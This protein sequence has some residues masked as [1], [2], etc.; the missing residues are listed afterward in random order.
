MLYIHPPTPLPVLSTIP[1]PR[2]RSHIRIINNPYFKLTFELWVINLLLTTTREDH[3]TVSF[4]WLQG[5]DQ[6]AI[7]DCTTMAEPPYYI[8]VSHSPLSAQTPGA[9]STALCHPVIQYHYAD[10]SPLSLLPQTAGEHVLVLDYDPASP[11][12]K[13][14][15]ANVAVTAL[16]VAEAPGAIAAEDELRKN[17]RMYIL[18]TTTTGEDK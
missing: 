16:K 13:S 8:L 5:V 3:V 10:D 17:D 1:K 6:T 18:E 14:I 2:S 11:N 15:S 12:A 9:P 7:L 4:V